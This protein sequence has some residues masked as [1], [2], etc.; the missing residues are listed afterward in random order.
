MTSLAFTV[1]GPPVP[2]ARPRVYRG[3]TITDPRTTAYEGLVRLHAVRE[4]QRAKQS[5]AWDAAALSY[6]VE[7]HFHMPTRR[8]ADVD[9]LAKGVLDACNGVL[10]ADDSAV[11][12]LR[13]TRVVDREQPRVVV[14]V[15]TEA[16]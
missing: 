10:W 4:V 5:H 15:S 16:A 3:H 14:L 9:N 11:C 8:R 12:D 2:K 13:I 7:L 1:P 6:R